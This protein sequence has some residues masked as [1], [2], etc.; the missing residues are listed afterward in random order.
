MSSA[1]V[2]TIACLA[3]VGAAGM[4]VWV[5]LQQRRT[6][7]LARSLTARKWDIVTLRA[8][9]GALRRQVQGAAPTD[10]EQ[11]V[12][13]VDDGGGDRHG[14]DSRGGGPRDDGPRSDG[15]E[16][17]GHEGVEPAPRSQAGAVR[18]PAAPSAWRRDRARGASSRP[19]RRPLF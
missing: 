5:A 8:E 6:D 19:R 16:G 3:L 10:D 18:S 13:A 7:E 1:T 11:P 2:A 12:R 14:G 15:P 4:A 17:D 9:L